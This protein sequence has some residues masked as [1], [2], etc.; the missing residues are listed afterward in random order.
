ML[1]WTIWNR[2]A[3][4]DTHLK[5]TC[6]IGDWHVWSTT[7]RRLTCLIRDQ[8][9]CLIGDTLENDMP[10]RRPTKDRHAWL[11]PLHY[12]N[13]YINN[14][15]V[16]KNKYIW[17]YTVSKFRFDSAGML[18]SDGSSQACRFP[19]RHVGLRSGR[20]V[21]AGEC[22]SPIRQIGLLWVFDRSLIKKI[23]SWTPCFISCK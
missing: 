17:I 19:I 13:I 22:Q 1:H 5:P 11:E 20:S 2:H 6:P 12:S 16:Y 18:V 3:S 4:L 14:Q 15:K 9:T 10:N 23:F 7:H 8:H 21:S